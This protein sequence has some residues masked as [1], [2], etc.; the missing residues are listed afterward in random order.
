MCTFVLSY[1]TTALSVWTR[2]LLGMGSS[3]WVPRQVPRQARVRRLST[4]SGRAPPWRHP[5]ILCLVVPGRQQG[6]SRGV[7]LMA[8]ER[9]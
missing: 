9:S 6:R 5:A 2:D 8:V 3:F 4:V 7:R 1:M